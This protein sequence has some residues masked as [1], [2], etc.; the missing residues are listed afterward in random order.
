[1]TAIDAG[2]DFDVLDR[3]PPSDQ[4]AEQSVLGAAMEFP[5]ELDSIIAVGVTEGDFYTVANGAVW[6]AINRLAHD[7]HPYDAV[8]VRAEM[9][10]AGTFRA[11]PNPAYL[12]DLAQ[13]AVRG[14]TS[15]HAQIVRDLAAK[16][17]AIVA[18]AR[19]L[20]A[21]WS[22]ATDASEVQ[23]EAERAVATIAAPVDETTWSTIDAIMGAVR[24]RYDETRAAGGPDG[25]RWGYADVDRVMTP[26]QPGDFAIVVAWA[27]G[28]KSV[29]AANLALDTALKQEKRAL[30]HAM[31]MT[32]LE[33]GQRYAA[34]TGSLKLDEII[35]GRLTLDQE[36]HLDWAI[37]QV[38]GAPLVIDEV[39]ALDL[40]K[41]RASIRKHRPALVIVDQIPIMLVDDPRASREQQLT[42]LSYSLK[43]LAASEGVVIVACAQLN[44]EPAKR[45][46]KLPTLQ[47]IRESRGIGQAANIAVF[48]HNPNSEQESARA[49]EIDWII[50]KQRQ[51]K[52]DVVIPMAQ[53]F[54]YSRLA[55]LYDADR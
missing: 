1:M 43:R 53:Q 45:S 19:I 48:L 26:M 23:A 20:Q 42:S 7:G 3:T 51:G 31:E 6:A 30:V 33:I 18:G 16:R 47:D 27:G 41:L 15:Y 29:V 32:R 34:K 36:D 24:D 40:A 13:A 11:M 2:P 12:F 10:R 14:S 49:G 44:S 38:R 5:G 8:S 4:H 46:D 50:R 55:D 9:L 22:P 25:I 54:H 28:G 17:R 21:A 52:S 39:P 35:A 37:M